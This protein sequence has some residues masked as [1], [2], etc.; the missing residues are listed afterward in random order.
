MQCKYTSHFLFSHLAFSYTILM[1]CV[2]PDLF[3]FIKWK[4]ILGVGMAIKPK[5]VSKEHTFMVVKLWSGTAVWI[6]SST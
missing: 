4:T 2:I 6:N 5:Q 1:F 3:R